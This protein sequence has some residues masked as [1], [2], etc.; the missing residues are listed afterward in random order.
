MEF[1]AAEMP[2]NLPAVVNN[3]QGRFTE[4][5]AMGSSKLTPYLGWVNSLDGSESLTE[6]EKSRI[7]VDSILLESITS[8]ADQRSWYETGWDVLG[9]MAVPD[10]SYNAAEIQA[11]LFGDTAGF[12]DWLGSAD[13]FKNIANFRTSLAPAERVM[14]DERLV[15]VIKGV[16]DN[17][18]QQISAVLGVLGRDHDTESF[19]AMEKFDALFIGAGLGA[20]LLKGMRSLNVLNRT[21]RVGDSRSV[22]KIA[23]AVTSSPEIA[24]ESGVVQVDAATVGNPVKPNGVF[25]GAPEGVQKKYR[26]YQGE[27]SAALEKAGDV[28]S[29]TARPNT[30]EADEIAASIKRNLAKHDDI[31]NIEVTVGLEQVNIKYDI[32]TPDGV[33]SISESRKFVLDDMGGFQQ[34]VAGM[35]GSVLRLATSSN[36][37]AGKD[38]GTFVQHAEVALLA[39]ARIQRSPLCR[40]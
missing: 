27:V 36:T 5:E 4:I 20:G 23:D 1:V 6:V 31:D 18:L 3:A 8:G 11:Q 33:K 26:D 38:R 40:S 13:A 15:E 17:K 14:F 25:T 16:D 9:M 37:L 34:Q 24:K 22:A 32:L 2:E 12:S 19:Q 35:I 7:A 39:K 10:E 28:L 29:I 30:K 21:A